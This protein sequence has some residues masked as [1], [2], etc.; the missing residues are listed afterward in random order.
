MLFPFGSRPAEC[1]TGRIDGCAMYEPTVGTDATTGRACARAPATPAATA[2]NAPLIHCPFIEPFGDKRFRQ[3]FRIFPLFRN[4]FEQFVF[5]PCRLSHA[6]IQIIRPTDTNAVFVSAFIVEISDI[7][8]IHP[9][10]CTLFLYRI[11]TRKD[12]VPAG[13]ENSRQHFGSDGQGIFLIIRYFTSCIFRRRRPTTYETAD[14]QA[15][16]S[17][18]KQN[19]RLHITTCGLLK[20]ILSFHPRHPVYKYRKIFTKNRKCR[21]SGAAIRPRQI[22]TTSVRTRNMLQTAVFHQAR[23]D[24]AH[25]QR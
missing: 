24:A 19:S 21:R 9:F 14:I 7:L 6:E 23:P 4:Y 16:H 2:E 5:R 3:S 8:Q 10:L 20:R 17:C 18:G 13:S 15:Q 1:R 12:A 25:A 11:D 22:R